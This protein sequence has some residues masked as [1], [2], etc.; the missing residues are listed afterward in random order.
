MKDEFR[1]TGVLHD[2]HVEL[3]EIIADAREAD[4]NGDVEGLQLALYR[5]ASAIGIPF[6]ED[7]TEDDH[8]AE[9]DSA[10]EDAQVAIQRAFSKLTREQKDELLLQMQK[11]GF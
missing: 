1:K 2:L 6:Y 3:M 11:G 9:L 8:D 5:V 10:E 7:D 4:M